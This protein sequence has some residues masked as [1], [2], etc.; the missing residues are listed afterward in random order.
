MSETLPRRRRQDD[1]DDLPL[2]AV[3]AHEARSFRE[4]VTIVAAGDSEETAVPVLMLAVSR[5]LAVGARLG[6][7][8]DVVLQHRFEP[9]TGA[10]AD[11]D[12]LR[13]ALAGVLRDGDSYT[14]TGDA[15]TLPEVVPGSIS[16]DIAVIAA[17]IAHGLRHFE[18]GRVDEALW[19]WQF[20]FLSTWGPRGAAALRA[21]ISLMTHAR[22]DVDADVASE[23][24]FEALHSQ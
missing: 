4:A 1:G 10:D 13:L 17:D 24:E 19:W 20:A 23:A 11:L 2:A 9:D 21:L 3:V 8:R 12:P 6:A 14:E 5:L 15:Q 22:L 7:T 18:A 16:D